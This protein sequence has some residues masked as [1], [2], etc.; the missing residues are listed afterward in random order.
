MNVCQCPEHQGLPGPALPP[1]ACSP[2]VQEHSS[3]GGGCWQGGKLTRVAVS[4][5]GGFCPEIVG[6]SQ[7]FGILS[8]SESSAYQQLQTDQS[9][10]PETQGRGESR[11]SSL[12][13]QRRD[14]SALLSVVRFLCRHRGI[15]FRKNTFLAT[16]PI[17]GG[18]PAC[19]LPPRATLWCSSPACQV[20]CHIS[21]H[22]FMLSA[23][24]YCH[25][26]LQRQ[27]ITQWMTSLV[28]LA[29]KLLRLFLQRARWQES[30]THL[31]DMLPA[32]TM[33]SVGG[34]RPS[35][36]MSPWKCVSSSKFFLWVKP[37]CSPPAEP[38]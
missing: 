21:D 5:L 10:C 30:S 4:A 36:I 38:Q 20:P 34:G 24:L 13:S 11:R 25:T 27:E 22:G 23:L 2:A 14:C 1:G 29:A 6:F 31:Q 26:F 35:V 7:T 16:L 33:A 9:T 3:P 17:A 12:L 32:Q 37:I 8:A 28:L 18:L 19:H 15:F